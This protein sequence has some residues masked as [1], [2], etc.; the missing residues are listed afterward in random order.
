MKRCFWFNIELIWVFLS[1]TDFCHTKISLIFFLFSCGLVFK[2]FHSGHY[3]SLVVL[4]FFFLSYQNDSFLG[5]ELFL[6]IT[7]M[8]TSSNCNQM[9]LNVNLYSVICEVCISCTL[10]IKLQWLLTHISS[11]SNF[12]CSSKYCNTTNILYKELNKVLVIT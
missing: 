3:D 7:V 5:C 8:W 12:P 1:D 4:T 10:V 11:F 9:A 6:G 2:N